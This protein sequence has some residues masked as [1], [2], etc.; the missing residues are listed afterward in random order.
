MTRRE[1]LQGSRTPRDS[2][3]LD[4]KGVS[5]TCVP[6]RAAWCAATSR[7]QQQFDTDGQG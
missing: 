4:A 5:V 7:R 3:L 6:C 1:P 2:L